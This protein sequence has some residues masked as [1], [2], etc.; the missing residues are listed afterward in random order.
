MMYKYLVACRTFFQSCKQ[1]IMSPVK[2]T[3]P[4]DHSLYFAGERES[5]VPFIDMSIAMDKG[6]S[7]GFQAYPLKGGVIS[8]GINSSEELD[9]FEGSMASLP[10]SMMTLH[11]KVTDEQ[12]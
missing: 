9:A 4:W 2:K 10:S 11:C 7:R 8:T 5:I 1:Q 3:G 12:V 6:L